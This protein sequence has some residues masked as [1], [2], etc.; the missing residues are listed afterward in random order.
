MLIAM[1]LVACSGEPGVCSSY[2]DT[3]IAVN[4]ALEEQGIPIKHFLLDSWWYGEGWNGGVSLWEGG[5]QL[6]PSLSVLRCCSP[7]SPSNV[8]PFHS[9]D[10]TGAP[11]AYDSTGRLTVS[12]VCENKTKREDQHKCIENCADRCFCVYTWMLKICVADVAACT[13]NDTS[14]EPAAFP[15]DTFPRG[16]KA[17]HKTVGEDKT[18]WVSVYTPQ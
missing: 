6:C 4:A 3:L 2:A 11:V 1:V 8:P 13:G 5:I 10:G 12:T 7:H 15:A 18:I 17:F 14:R 16:L 9:R